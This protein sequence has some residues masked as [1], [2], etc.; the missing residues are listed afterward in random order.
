VSLSVRTTG[1]DGE[2]DGLLMKSFDAAR[3]VNFGEDIFDRS[4]DFSSVDHHAVLSS[5]SSVDQN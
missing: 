3:T 5:N 1:T 4:V 2:D